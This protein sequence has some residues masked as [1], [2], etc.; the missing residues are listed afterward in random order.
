MEHNHSTTSNTPEVFRTFIGDTIKGVV[1]NKEATIL[2][3][4]CG[5]G[6]AIY[7]NGSHWVVGPL[8]VSILIERTK[9][10]LENTKKELKDILHLA[11]K[12]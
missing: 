10:E 5:W 11:G 7:Y 8:E 2:A 1:R 9:K 4:E 6:L 3:F 12:S